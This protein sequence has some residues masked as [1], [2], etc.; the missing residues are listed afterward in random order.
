MAEISLKW[1]DLAENGWNYWN[2]LNGP[3]MAG[4]AEN[5]RKGLE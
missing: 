3:E 1:P 2:G 5:G 4:R